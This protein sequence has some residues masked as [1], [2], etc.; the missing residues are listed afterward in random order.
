MRK[1]F[2]ECIED[3]FRYSFGADVFIICAVMRL[4]GVQGDGL[5][6]EIK[7]SGEEL[8]NFIKD[9]APTHVEEALPQIKPENHYLLTAWDW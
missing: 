1:A 8:M 4:P 2:F 3:G 5:S 9:F 6:Y 7:M